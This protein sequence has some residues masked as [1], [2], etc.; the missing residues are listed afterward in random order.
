MKMIHKSAGG[1]HDIQPYR[2]NAFLYV[3]TPKCT[4]SMHEII[5]IIIIIIFAY[6]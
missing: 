2:F 3:A 5:M 1:L 4:T 6:F